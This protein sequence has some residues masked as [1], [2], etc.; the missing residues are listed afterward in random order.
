[1]TSP[2]I[3]PAVS[4]IYMYLNIDYFKKGEADD[5][6]LCTR[7]NYLFCILLLYN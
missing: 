7:T 2:S 1:M 4:L 6:L 3:S 5:H